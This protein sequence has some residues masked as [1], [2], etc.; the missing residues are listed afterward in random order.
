MCYVNRTHIWKYAFKLAERFVLEMPQGAQVLT[1]Q[2]QHGTPVI[3]ARVDPDAPQESRHFRL[4]GTG[5][6]LGRVGNYVGTFQMPAHQLVWHLYEA[7]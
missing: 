1:V 3:W 6:A 5:H 2:E 7:L 4:C